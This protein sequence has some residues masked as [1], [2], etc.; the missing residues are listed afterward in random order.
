MKRKQAY[1]KFMFHEKKVTRFCMSACV[2]TRGT[3]LRV[4]VDVNFFYRTVG[5]A[6]PNAEGSYIVGRQIFDVQQN[7]NLEYRFATLSIIV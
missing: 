4:N 7:F 1:Q 5:D 3:S 2:P 6:V